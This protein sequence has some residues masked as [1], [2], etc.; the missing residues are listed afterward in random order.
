MVHQYLSGK[1]PLG[2]DATLKW[3]AYLGV[4]P[5]EIR[6]DL[7]GVTSLAMP[8]LD[9]QLLTQVIHDVE[10]ILQERG[11]RL[12]FENHAK[13]IAATYRESLKTRHVDKDIIRYRADV[14]Q[15]QL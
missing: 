9:M 11:T 8:G 3:A 12:S 6:D 13:L 7:A 4:D 1:T 14:L 5:V 2:T 15:M 10:E